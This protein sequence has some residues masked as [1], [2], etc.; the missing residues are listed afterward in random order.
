MAAIELFRFELICCMDSALAGSC[1]ELPR[2]FMA[3]S[4]PSFAGACTLCFL[5]KLPLGCELDICFVFCCFLLPGGSMLAP[6]P[7]FF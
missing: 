4:L 7:K 6:A 3:M 2:M 1:C 5:M